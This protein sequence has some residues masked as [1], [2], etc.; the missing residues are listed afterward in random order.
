MLTLKMAV[1]WEVAPCSLAEIDGDFGGTFYLHLHSL[2]NS[3][4]KH[5]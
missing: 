3:G 1:F 4:S 2:E 5:L